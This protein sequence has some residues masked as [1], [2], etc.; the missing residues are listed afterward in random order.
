MQVILVHLYLIKYLMS[1]FTTCIKV[2][3]DFRKLVKSFCNI[4]TLFLFWC[5]FSLHKLLNSFSPVW[6]HERNTPLN[7]SFLIVLHEN[8][9]YFLVFFHLFWVYYSSYCMVFSIPYPVFFCRWFLE[10]VRMHQLL[11]LLIIVLANLKPSSTIR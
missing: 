11:Q 6:I 3:Y 2:S 10:V 5:E 8:L 1:S 7:S 9:I 4:L